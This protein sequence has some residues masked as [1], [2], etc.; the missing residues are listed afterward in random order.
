MKTMF[1]A[2]KVPLLVIA[3]IIACC[4]VKGEAR[5]TTAMQKISSCVLG[6]P[7]KQFIRVCIGN[8]RYAI[9][10][11]SI[12]EYYISPMFRDIDNPAM[13]CDCIEYNQAIKEYHAK[14]M[15]DYN[16][17]MAEKDLK[18]GYIALGTIKNPHT[19][20]RRP[21][22]IITS[23]TMPNE[24]VEIS[25]KDLFEADIKCVKCKTIEKLQ[26]VKCEDLK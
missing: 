19:K 7:K 15:A 1:K 3:L 17:R 11:D 5:D 4:A 25:E 14:L 6:S 8:K 13:K 24:I 16:K 12:G 2:N 20:T 26:C 9:E 18:Y 22:K 21:V 23:G 10:R